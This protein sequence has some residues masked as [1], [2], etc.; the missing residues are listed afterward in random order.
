MGYMSWLLAILGSGTSVNRYTHISE[1]CLYIYNTYLYIY[2]KNS[3]I[4]IK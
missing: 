4:K 2:N 1:A 3:M